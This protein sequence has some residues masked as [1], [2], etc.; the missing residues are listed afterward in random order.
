MERYDAE[1]A[2]RAWREKPVL[3]NIYGE[4]HRMIA[5]QLRKGEPTL[6][7][8]SG[9]GNLK[10]VVP[11]CMTSDLVPSPWIDRIESTYSLSFS[12]GSLGNIV[13]FDVFHHLKYPGLA[14]AECAR[15]LGRQG[16]LIIFDHDFGL[17]GAMV[18]AWFHPEP[19]G[20]GSDIQWLPTEEIDLKNPA[21]YAA[22]ANAYRVFV[23]RSPQ[24]LLQ[25]RDSWK[26]LETRRICSFRYVAS[27]GYSGPQLYPDFMYPFLTRLDS[28]LSR[29]P[30]VFSTRLLVVLE[31]A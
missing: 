15:V 9:F 27:G 29:F 5:E 7:I 18:H 4:F 2:E 19:T 16:R 24:W 11:D 13:Y 21:Y 23:R 10:S 28:V 17:L 22:T 3:R 12:N 1:K 31:K 25:G 30:A 14:L 26:T 6:E 8:G 20:W